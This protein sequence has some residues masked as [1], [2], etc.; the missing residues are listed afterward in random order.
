MQAIIKSAGD[1]LL[2]VILLITLIYVVLGGMLKGLSMITLTVPI[3][4]PIVAAQGFDLI[5]FATLRFSG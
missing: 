1:H 2:F 5:W 3:L 4:Y